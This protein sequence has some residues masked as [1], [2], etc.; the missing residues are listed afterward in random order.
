MPTHPTSQ[1]ESRVVRLVTGRLAIT[2][3]HSDWPLDALCGF[4]SRHNPARGYL[5]ISKVLGKHHPVRPKVMA[6]IHSRLAGKILAA[7]PTGPVVAIAMAETATALGAGVFD[8]C[9]RDT[10][11]D[12]WLFLH[13]TRYRLS[14]PVA[15]T[16]T[17][18]HCHAP[19]HIVYEPASSRG[20]ALLHG[21][22]TLILIDDEISTG[23]TL[24]NLARAATRAA[25]G[26]EKI[27][28]VS[29]KCWQDADGRAAMAARFPR[30]VEFAHMLAGRFEFQPDAAAPEPTLFKSV[31]DG[32]PKDRF[33]PRND[34]RFGLTA[35]EWRT[36]ARGGIETQIRDIMR[37][38]EPGG[39]R[40]M[41]VLGTG[42]F[43]WPPYLL[44][45]RLEEE[46]FDIVFQ[47]SS[48]TPIRIGNDIANIL[49][50]EDNYHDGIDNFL[51]NVDPDC[52]RGKIVCYETSPLPA[53]HDLPRRLR[54]R[55]VFFR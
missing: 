15:F 16:L 51:Y 8:A 20:S 52:P 11:A 2:V 9:L 19:N 10:G 28:L 30:P 12:D 39:E 18:D 38:L 32:S 42:E 36:S 29:I 53:A 1:P 54:A 43:S 13:T 33:L 55:T 27:L 41:L 17:E 50:F 34:G 40:S 48:R 37:D 25:P 23:N 31:G 3:E 7:G 26:L 4:A 6:E 46:G 49:C 35:T 24:L 47:S 21:A 5:F 45:R 14:R 22:R 44:A